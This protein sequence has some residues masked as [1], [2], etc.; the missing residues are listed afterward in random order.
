MNSELLTLL[1]K[2][3]DNSIVG[4]CIQQALRNKQQEELLFILKDMAHDNPQIIMPIIG[5][6]AFT[7]LSN[8]MT[9]IPQSGSIR[10]QF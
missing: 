1:E 5:K 4:L 7:L 3:N 2:V 9:G 10:N 8:S 6:K